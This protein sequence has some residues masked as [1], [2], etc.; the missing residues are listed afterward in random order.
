MN[1]KPAKLMIVI[2]LWILTLISGCYGERRRML[3]PGVELSRTTL[4]YVLR[5]GECAVCLERL[6]PFVRKMETEAT[7]LDQ[8]VLV[9]SPSGTDP[10]G[11]GEMLAIPMHHGAL[12]ATLRATG[13]SAFLPMMY[14]VT[15]GKEIIFA[16]P[17]TFSGHDQDSMKE[18]ILQ[19]RFEFGGP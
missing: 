16:R 18:E 2:L 10:Q 11:L 19:L 5:E 14:L 9:L 13:T 7:H 3:F 4:L 12:D 15:P 1:Q 8:A 6:E 17:I